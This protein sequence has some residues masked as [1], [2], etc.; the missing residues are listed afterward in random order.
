MPG[1]KLPNFHIIGDKLINPI[2]GV[3]IPIIRIPI[4][5]GI[6]IPNIATFDHGT[7]YVLYYRILYH[8]HKT[9]PFFYRL[10]KCIGIKFPIH[11]WYGVGWLVNDTCG[12]PHVFLKTFRSRALLW[13]WL[14]HRIHGT[15]IFTYM[16]GWYTPYMDPMGMK[17][18]DMNLVKLFR[19]LTNRPISP[20]RWLFG[21]EI[22]YF[23]EIYNLA[24][25]MI[26]ALH[27]SYL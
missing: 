6:T 20:K 24:R 5:G 17:R 18:F 22:P 26:G 19:D 13:N 25:W 16:N 15:G 1:S 12:G 7:Y 14:S 2:V 11:G 8:I 21:R 10:G 3:Y 4:K 9:E 23:R 27:F